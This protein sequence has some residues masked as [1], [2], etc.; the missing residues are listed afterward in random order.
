M[1]IS[2]LFIHRPAGTTLLTIALALASLIAYQFLPVA[3][4]PQVEFP[5]IQVQAQLPGASPEIMASAV[6]TPLERQFGRI[7][8]LNEMTST[9]YLGSTNISLQFTLERLQR[10]LCRGW[11]SA[12]TIGATRVPAPVGASQALAPGRRRRSP[13]SVRIRRSARDRR[14]VRARGAV[15]RRRRRATPRQ[16]VG[17]D[18]GLRSCFFAGDAL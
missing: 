12:R 3:P 8:G 15:L 5:T 4:L 18:G 11:G 13:G 14:R 2:A 16:G 1:N 6:A 9:S 10:L 17:R 7:A